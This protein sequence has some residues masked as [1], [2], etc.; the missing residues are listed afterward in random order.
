[1]KLFVVSDIHS[2]YTPLIEALNKAGFDPDNKDHW[3]I[4]CGDCFDRG[5]ESVEVL[6]YLMQLER[7]ILIKGNHDLLLKDLCSRGFPYSH[8]KSNGTV[9][10]VQDFG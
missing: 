7:K 3:L 4:S 6:H 1:V 8:D 2:F 9:R 10:T 5:P